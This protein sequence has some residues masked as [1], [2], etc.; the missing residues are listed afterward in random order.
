VTDIEPCPRCRVMRYKYTYQV[1]PRCTTIAVACLGC[2]YVGPE[3]PMKSDDDNAA[4]AQACQDW[5]VAARKA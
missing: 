2:G 1:R 3:V 4:A 5:D